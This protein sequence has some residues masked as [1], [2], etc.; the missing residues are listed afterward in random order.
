MPQKNKL[1]SHRFKFFNFF[2]AKDRNTKKLNPVLEKELNAFPDKKLSPLIKR[3]KARLLPMDNGSQQFFL[4]HIFLPVKNKLNS[5]NLKNKN[6]AIHSFFQNLFLIPLNSWKAHSIFFIFMLN[7][8]RESEN[9]DFHQ[10]SLYIGS[11]VSLLANKF[12]TYINKDHRFHLGF[13]VR[14]ASYVNL[15]NRSVLA[16][17]YLIALIEKYNLSDELFSNF[18]SNLTS[19]RNSEHINIILE[20]LVST[21]I[22]LSFDIFVD[23]L[24]LSLDV[25]TNPA[26]FFSNIVLNEEFFDNFNDPEEY[27]LII[28]KIIDAGM[29]IYDKKW[30]LLSYFLSLISLLNKNENKKIDSD[31][32]FDFITVYADLDYARRDIFIHSLLDDPIS[33]SKQ[34][35]RKKAEIVRNIKLK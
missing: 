17:Q 28:T 13:P 29:R 2:K 20:K 35:I 26:Y 14:Q 23:L 4:E 7:R 5:L 9:P 25:R 33:F 30:S 8:L 10:I 1:K 16:T 6:Q 3:L 34:S 18:I 31:V 19:F 22:N 11:Y 15:N 12:F 24:D 21:K 32:F 27:L